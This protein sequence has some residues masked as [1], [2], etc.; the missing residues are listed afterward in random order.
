MKRDWDLVRAILLQVEQLPTATSQVRAPDVSGW[1]EELVGWH[2]ALLVDAGIVEG[3][4]SRS[5]GRAPT[6]AV[7]GLTWA[8]CELLDSIRRPAVWNAVRVAAREGAVELTLEVIR[9][10][11]GRV[12]AAG[13]GVP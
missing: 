5:L 6:T 8:G 2:L 7:R 4:V 13:I 10:L 11:A 1:D 3:N 9:T 12:A